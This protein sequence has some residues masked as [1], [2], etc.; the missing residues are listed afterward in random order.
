M[1][2]GCGISKS[3]LIQDYEDTIMKLLS[4]WSTNKK[5]IQAKSI[6]GKIWN[7]L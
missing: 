3:S 1:K 7:Q 6:K 5:N 2:L 4:Y